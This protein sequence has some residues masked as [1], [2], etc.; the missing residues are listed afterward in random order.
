[1]LELKNVSLTYDPSTRFKK[2]ALIDVSLTINKAEAISMVGHIGSGKSTLVQLLNGLIKPDKGFVLLNGNDINAKG[3]SRKEVI[4]SV[5][6]VFQY[7]EEQFFAETVFE[8]IAF[9]PRNLGF[10]KNDVE[11]S[12]YESL[13]IMGFDIESILNRS[14]FE[15]SGGEKR[16]VAIASVI[17][18]RPHILVLDEPTAGMDYN[19]TK[20]IVSHIGKEV[21]R[22]T[23]VV[24][25]THN[26]NEALSV[27]KRIIA[28]K[29]GKI[30]FD[31]PTEK[32]FSDEGLVMSTG[33]DIPFAVSFRSV[34]LNYFNDFQ[35]V[36]SEEEI[37]KALLERK[38]AK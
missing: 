36:R 21:A 1:M 5:G 15:L 35:F 22:G 7:P 11:E 24:F 25:V 20:S 38:V 19:G 23:T 12:V 37:A 8:E 29:S 4:K 9:G 14:P 31:G 16:R 26:M 17:S 32:F 13:R 30:I 6:V 28:L 2:E 18:M 3:F 27:S 33:L 10:N 34:A